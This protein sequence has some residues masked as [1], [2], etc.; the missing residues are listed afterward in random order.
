VSYDDCVKRRAPMLLVLLL[1]VG[2][3]IVNVAVA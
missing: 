2:G 3:A 1:L